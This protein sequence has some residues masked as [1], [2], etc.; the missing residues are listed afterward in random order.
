M[1]TYH[2]PF[3]NHDLCEKK[4]PVQRFSDHAK[5]IQ[6]INR[7]SR[8]NRVVDYLDISSVC[9]KVHVGKFLEVLEMK[10]VCY[11]LCFSCVRLKTCGN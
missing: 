6:L 7:S 2:Y 9:L 10:T 5:V 1:F 11:T 4:T 3:E 8:L